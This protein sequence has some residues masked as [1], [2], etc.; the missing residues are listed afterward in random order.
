V[1]ACP[2]DAIRF[3]EE[4]ELLELIDRATVLKPETGCEPSVYYLNIPG[5]FIAGTVYDPIQ[6]EI[7]RNA[8]CSLVGN[9]KSL[10]A[11][12]DGFGDFWFKDL[13]SG[14]YDLTIRA[15]GFAPKAFAAVDTSETDVNLGDIPLGRA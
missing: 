1:E 12:T 2:T 8:E 11:R 4:A 3:G 14:L 6:E 13:E 9:G 7:V 5:R 15:K 10:T